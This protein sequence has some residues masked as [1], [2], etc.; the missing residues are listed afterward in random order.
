MTHFNNSNTRNNGAFPADISSL[1]Q[2]SIWEMKAVFEKE[3][4]KDFRIFLSGGTSVLTDFAFGR[5]TDAYM[6]YGDLI[7]Q[8][9]LLLKQ[10]PRPRQ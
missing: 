4:H 5:K 1:T 7:Q 8:R 2:E 10:R 9:V 3:V 6:D